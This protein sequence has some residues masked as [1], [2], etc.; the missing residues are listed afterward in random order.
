MWRWIFKPEV[1]LFLGGA[2]SLF[3]YLSW[4]LYGPFPLYVYSA[5]YIPLVIWIVGYV[6]FWIGAKAAGLKTFAPRTNSLVRDMTPH[7]TLTVTVSVAL[8]LQMIAFR[9]VYGG[10]P[11]LQYLAGRL[12]AAGS[13]EMT[14]TRAFPGQLGLFLVS[15][16]VL[17]G[18]IVILLVSAAAGAKPRRL[19]LISSMLISL[20]A[21]LST[22]KRQTVAIFLVMVACSC[23]LYYGNPVRPVLRYLGIRRSKWL[24]RLLLV[25]VPLLFIAF[26]GY[27]VRLRTGWNVS[28]REHVLATWHI[29]LINFET[30]VAEIGYGPKR[31]DPLRLTQYM[32]PDRVFRRVARFSEERPARGEW[33][34]SAGFYGDLHWNTGVPGVI[35]FSLF[36]GWLS[37]YFYLRARSSLFHLLTYS[38]MCWTLIG[39]HSYNHFLHLNFLLLPSALYWIL[40]R[41]MS[42]RTAVRNE[43]VAR[44]RAFALPRFGPIHP[45]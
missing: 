20:A 36:A 29:G 14:F 33:T 19:L 35:V 41:L 16:L 21:G 7:K 4:H 38:L 26:L 43:A 10:I 39:A 17:D 22:G 15:Q 25:G 45:R 3:P 24:G 13:E 2:Q 37:K 28:G 1:L 34:A 23:A 40:A 42:G 6:A 11:F 9:S 27:V 18:L 8:V 12:D 30:Q 31:Y 5:T 44:R 32:V